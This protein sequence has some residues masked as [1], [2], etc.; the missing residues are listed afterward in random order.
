MP[1]WPRVYLRYKN[2]SGTNLE[3]ARVSEMELFAEIVNCQEL[4]ASANDDNT[5]A[6]NDWGEN[7]YFRYTSCKVQSFFTY[8]ELNKHL[9]TCL[10][11]TRDVIVTDSQPASSRAINDLQITTESQQHQNAREIVSQEFTNIR[12]GKQNLREVSKKIQ[13][14]YERIVFWKKNLWKKNL[15]MLPT[16]AAAKKNTQQRQQ[17]WWMVGRTIHHLKISLL[18]PYISCP[19]FFSKSRANFLKRK[20]IWKHWREELTYRAKQRLTSFYL[21]ARQFNHVLPQINTRKSIGE[22]S[23]KFALLM[24]KGMWMM[25]CYYWQAIFLTVYLL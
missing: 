5:D 20:T 3:P 14:A 2:V 24:E 11:K 4:I 12:W 19:V 8:R 1:Y 9:R 21:R 6:T 10:R 25:R 18:R 17:N 15:F 16:G 13:D 7:D 23:K 22:L